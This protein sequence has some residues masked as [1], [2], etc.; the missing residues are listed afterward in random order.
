[1]KIQYQVPNDLELYSDEQIEEWLVNDELNS[2]TAEKIK[3]LLSH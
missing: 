1:M 2:A 3:T